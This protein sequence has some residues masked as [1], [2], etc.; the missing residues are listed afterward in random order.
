V[1]RCVT[2]SSSYDNLLLIDGGA[3]TSMLGPDFY[4]ESTSSRTVTVEGFGGSDTVIRNMSLGNGITKVAINGR[5]PFL[6]RVND[7][8]ITSH[9]SI[10]SSNQLRHYGCKVKISHKNTM[11]DRVFGYL[12]GHMYPSI[13]EQLFVT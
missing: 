12:M 5:D 4:I 11:E 2:A 8:I 13:T 1:V 7:G 3:D 9:K 10:L 6:M